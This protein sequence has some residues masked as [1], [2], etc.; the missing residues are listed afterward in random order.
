MTAITPIVPIAHSFEWDARRG[1]FTGIRFRLSDGSE[2]LVAAAITVID[3]VPAE[4]APADE[5]RVDV[6]V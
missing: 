3:D 2:R 4:D 1:R 6:R 5:W